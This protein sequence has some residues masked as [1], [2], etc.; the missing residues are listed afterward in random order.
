MM[1]DDFDEEIAKVREN[2]EL[3][4]LLDER[5]KEAGEFPLSQVRE[6]L[7]EKRKM[8]EKGEAAPPV[9]PPPCSNGI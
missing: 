1:S 8:Q 6:Q 2:T 5:S 3:L 9:S 7:Q 4:R